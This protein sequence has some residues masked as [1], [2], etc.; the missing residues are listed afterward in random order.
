MSHANIMGE[1][2]NIGSS[3]A[4]IM[5]EI[6]NIGSSHANIMG[7]IQNIGSSHAN[8]MGEIQNIGSSHANIMG[9][10]QN[11]GQNKGMLLQE[12]PVLLNRCYVS[13]YN[14]DQNLLESF[15]VPRIRKGT[16]VSI[17]FSLFVYNETTG[18]A[19]G[20]VEFNDQVLTT[21][22]CARFE[23]LGAGTVNVDTFPRNDIDAVAVALN[24]VR[25]VGK[26]NGFV[27]LVRGTCNARLMKKADELAAIDAEKRSQVSGQEFDEKTAAAIKMSLEEN[28][29]RMSQVQETVAAMGE[30]VATAA[31]YEERLMMSDRRLMRTETIQDQ[32]ADRIG[33]QTYTL[34]QLNKKI[35]HMEREIARLSAVINQKDL[36]LGEKDQKF[37]KLSQDFVH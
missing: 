28:K 1:I 14:A 30:K 16:D 10:I 3:H 18:A 35:A 8:I 32:Q 27:E 15:T 36:N 24:H 5:E 12:S 9:E 2:Q 29:E 31:Q 21:T 7:E 17:R 20:F 26:S 33:G 6:Q 4:N 11:I 34:N 22:V 37:M 23:E 19:E 13:M 25:D